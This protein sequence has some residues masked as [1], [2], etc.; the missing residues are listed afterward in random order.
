MTTKIR[1]KLNAMIEGIR[2]GTE[3]IGEFVGV[4]P[5]LHEDG[6]PV[7]SRAYGNPL[8]VLKL[9]NANGEE[10]TFWAD[11][12]LRGALKIARVAPGKAIA[13]MAT[14]ETQKV[15]SGEVNVYEIFDATDDFAAERRR[16]G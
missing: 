15:E 12:G 14:G 13:I 4:E 9:R 11:G 7:V 3:V 1:K 16:V 8:H 6:T 10:A 5:L 2:P